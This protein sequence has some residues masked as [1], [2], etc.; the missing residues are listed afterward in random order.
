MIRRPP[1][2]TLFPYTTL[3]RSDDY[4]G[5]DRPRHRQKR[6]RDT[7]HH[8]QRRHDEDDSPGFLNANPPAY[9]HENRTAARDVAN[10]ETEVDRGENPAHL[11]P[12]T[13]TALLSEIGGEPVDAEV[14]A[15]INKHRHHQHGEKTRTAD[16]ARENSPLPC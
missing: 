9:Q 7:K 4:Q 15:R 6:N 5:G 12:G 16:D 1:R 14:K 3:F 13:E 2:S 10:V 11:R 8:G